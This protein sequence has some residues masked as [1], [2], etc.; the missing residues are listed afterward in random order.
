MRER[1]DRARAL[2]GCARTEALLEADPD[3]EA[4][5][6]YSH[7]L[8]WEI[9]RLPAKKQVTPVILLDTF[10]DTEDRHRDTERLLQRLV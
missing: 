7:L 9:S 1:R 10:E 5:S 2:A 3:L 8:S 4:L 6:F